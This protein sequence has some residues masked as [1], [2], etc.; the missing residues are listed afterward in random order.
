V[1]AVT[2]VRIRFGTSAALVFALAALVSGQDKKD[3]P[4]ADPKPADPKVDGKRF[5]T[6][7]DFDK[8]TKFYQESTTTL[9]QVI[10]VQGQDLTQTQRSTFFFEWTPVKLE[11]DKAFVKQRVEGVQMTIDISGNQINYDSTKG[12]TP[13]AGNPGLTEF[14]KKLTG[15]EFTAVI[16]KGVKVVEV[17]GKADFIKNLA[18]GSPQMETLLSK[19]L[20]D[21]ALRDMCDPTLKLVPED[22][23]KKVGDTWTRKGTINLGPIGTYTVTYNFKYVGVEKDLD[24][25]EVE[26]KLEYAAPKKDDP[27]AGGLLF[28]INDG[29]LGINPDKPAKG[30]I[31]YDPKAGRVA[32]AEITINLKGELTVAIGGTD[33]K[34]ELL[35]EQKTTVKTADGSLLP[36]KK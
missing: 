31:M 18:T 8:K 11:G 23:P 22:G 34:V 5:E 28:R 19:I 30:V 24:K 17:Q 13:S 4:K 25:I 20:T 29:K 15:A 36:V 7:F 27:N 14:F 21:D 35:Q 26:T 16:E 2:V 3:P 10:K 1:E 6:R 33:T 9:T 32:S 12:D